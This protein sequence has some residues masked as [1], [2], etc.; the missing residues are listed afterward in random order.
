M[1]KTKPVEHVVKKWESKASIATD[2]YKFGVENPKEDW[3]SATEGAFSRW[4]AGIQE[5]ISKKTLIGGVRKAGTGKW[6]KRALEKGAGRYAEGIRT[7]TDEYRSAMG[8]VLKVI[9]GVDLPEKGAKGDPKNYERV[10]AIGEAL[11]KWKIARKT[12]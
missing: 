6:K 4:Q 10:K 2:D 3:A 12:A 11:H 8:E 7:A 1:V 9:E 5:S